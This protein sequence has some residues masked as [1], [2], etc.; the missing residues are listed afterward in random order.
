M[1]YFL[2]SKN[3]Q[4]QTIIIVLKKWLLVFLINLITISA[5][6]AYQIVHS[7]EPNRVDASV[8]D[9]AS[10]SGNIYVFIDQN[11]G[12]KAVKFYV[13]GNLYHSEGLSPWDFAG[14]ANNYDSLP[15][16]TNGLSDGAHIIRADLTLSDN[17]LQSLSA[18]IE[19]KNQALSLTVS[20]GSL[21]ETVYAKTPFSK[22]VSVQTSNAAAV[23]IQLTADQPWLSF[24][25]SGGISPLNAQVT[26]DPSQLADG[27]YSAIIT[28]SAAGYPNVTI[29]VSLTLTAA[30]ADYQLLFATKPD[31]SDGIA[32]NSQLL[33]G[34]VYVYLW[35]ESNVKQVRFYVDNPGLTGTAYHSESIAPYD[36]VGTAANAEALAFDAPSL[37]DGPHSIGAIITL[38]DGSEVF[39]L[40]EFTVGLPKAFTLTPSQLQ[41]AVTQPA[42][43]ASM[44]LAIDFA[45]ASL[46]SYDISTNQPWLSVSPASGI[47]PSSHSVNVDVSS[48]TPGNYA[49]TLTVSNGIQSAQVPVLLSYTT[50]A[51]TYTLQ[52]SA[53]AN[54]SNSQTL[55][56]ASVDGTVYIHLQPETDVAKVEF[57]LDRSPAGAP[58]KIEKLAPYDWAGTATSGAANPFDSHQLADG[59]HYMYAQVTH[60]SG[61]VESIYSSFQ[62]ANNPGAIPAFT[63]TPASLVANLTNTDTAK[64]YSVLLGLNAAGDGSSPDFQAASNVTWASV[65]PSSGNAPL[66]LTVTLNPSGLQPGTYQGIISVSSSQLA[67]TTLPINLSVSDSSPQLIANP[68]SVSLSYLPSSGVHTSSLDISTSDT[69]SIY[70]VVSDS[71]WLTTGVGSGATPQTLTLNLDTYG[72]SEGV[73][74]GHLT[75]T[76]NGYSD[77]VVP[78]SLSINSSDACAP[79]ICTQIRVPLP[80]RLDFDADAGHLLDQDGEGTGFTYIQPASNTTAYQ[81]D[82]VDLDRAAGVLH[83]TTTPGIAYLA[84]NN[85]ANALGVGFAGPN[86]IARISTQLNHPAKGAGKYEQA[87]L[88]FGVN[89]DN[90]VKLVYN[91]Y[92]NNPVVEFVY[93][94]NGAL[95]KST[96]K[97]VGDLSSSLLTLALVADPSTGLVTASYAIDGGV[98]TTLIAQEVEPE[99]FSFDAAGIDPLI[100]TRSFTGLMVTQR[101]STLPLTFEFEYFQIEAV[102]QGSA[103]SPVNFS[104][105]AY[106]I[107]FPTNMVWGPNG[108]LYVTEMFGTVHELTYDQDLNVVSDQIIASLTSTLGAR[109]TLGITVHQDDPNDANNF[110]LWIS[111]SSPSL[112]KGVANS[113][114]VTR[115]SGPGFTQVEQIITG[116]PR[117]IANHAINSLHFGVDDRLYIAIAGNTGA[118]APVSVPTE[119]GDREEQPLSAAILVADVFAPAFDGSCANTSNIYGPAPCDLVPFVTGL[120]NSYD[121]VFHSNGEIYATDNGLGVT[122]AFPHSPV[123]DCSGL[124]DPALVSDGGNN[125]GVQDDLLVRVEA[126]KYYGHPNPSRDQCVFKDGSLQG[127]AALPNYEPPIAS[128]GK[129]ASADGIIEYTSSRACG[130][131]KGDLLISRYSLGDDVLQVK[132]SSDG[133]AV[134]SMSSLI[135]GFNDPLTIRERNG[136]LFVAELGGGQITALRPELM[137]CMDSKAPLPMAIL[138]AAGATSGTKLYVLGGRTSGGNIDNAFAYDSQ[139]DTWTLL[140]SKPGAL[141]DSAAAAAAGNFIY[142]V[143][144]YAGALRI[145]SSEVWRYD[146]ANNSWQALAPLLQ[147]LAGA[148]AVA[149]NGKIYLAGGA[150]ANGASQNS[151]YIFDIASGSWSTGPSMSAARDM[152]GALVVNGKLYVLG[153][154]QRLADGTIQSQALA[155]VEIFDPATNSWSS[156]A[157]M[158]RGRRAFALGV[159]NDKVVVLGGEGD[160]QGAGWLYFEID[161]LDTSTNTWS[162]LEAATVVRHGTA[163]GT[164]DNSL[165]FSG[166]GDVEGDSFKDTTQSFTIN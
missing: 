141:V 57:Y 105:S 149:I 37:G 124:A 44:S 33:N 51:E 26:I 62:V 25:V 85:Q 108:K 126:G 27:N 87:G 157:S 28:A 43:Q 23:D 104:R 116:L 114:T 13:D 161:Q 17:S 76:A 9:G 109:L 163:F 98:S 143:G 36:L 10:V 77:L 56:G 81:A 147:P 130:K 74:L 82:K 145:P 73:Y 153:G 123:P 75:V 24:S 15:F 100:G 65:A 111:S 118:G 93:E 134:Q 94:K 113:S 166:G 52:I 16:D 119:F 88:W 32:L 84:N 30:S 103:N 92:P 158:P 99:M 137:N 140:A 8:L 96:N 125:P 31:R 67:T 86:Q 46:Q 138:D 139:S 64:D 70:S 146:I 22:S 29:P 95:V 58:D 40:S 49:A 135:T 12:L 53:Q 69:S 164:I 35:P 20:P 5:A 34:A 42:T 50:L 131:L 48:L 11:T 151:L 144:G 90:Y 41:F 21:S 133:K 128:P 107:N 165:Y 97:V 79:V 148:R 71:S 63:L 160:P 18:S 106:P 127:V 154:R 112:D 55:A 38:E 136:D 152:A 72:L 162:T 110:S 54:R 47:T 121:F 120:R 60:S 122:G 3:L 102:D 142:V 159:I 132:L 66:S 68:A 2:P 61:A 78:V 156:G 155:N 83:L 6:A 14:T 101:N 39:A 117:A 150:A 129:N 80:Y 4:R 7:S 91:S 19:V 115:L 45:D 59:S 1:D 89:E